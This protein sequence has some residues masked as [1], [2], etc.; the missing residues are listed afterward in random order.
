MGSSL[1]T[2]PVFPSTVIRFPYPN[3]PQRDLKENP[4]PAPPSSYELAAHSPKEAIRRTA[5]Y[6]VTMPSRRRDGCLPGFEN[7]PNLSRALQEYPHLW[8][9]A[10]LALTMGSNG[11]EEGDLLSH[12]ADLQQIPSDSLDEI[13]G[14]LNDI[15][16]NIGNQT[17][18]LLPT[19]RANRLFLL[20]ETE[21]SLP[22]YR[23]VLALTVMA[24]LGQ[25]MKEVGGSY[26]LG[27]TVYRDL[28]LGNQLR[29]KGQH[30]AA[31]EQYYQPACE[32]NPY[33]LCAL[34]AAQSALASQG[35]PDQ[36][37]LQSLWEKYRQAHAEIR[38]IADTLS[39]VPSRRRVVLDYLKL[40]LWPEAVRHRSVAE[41]L[42]LGARIVSAI[43]NAVSKIVKLI[44]G[45]PEALLGII[46]ILGAANQQ[47]RMAHEIWG[48]G[49]SLYTDNFT[50][51]PKLF[52]NSLQTELI[53]QG[54]DELV[55]SEFERNLG[56]FD[57]PKLCQ[58]FVR[59]PSVFED[60]RALFRSGSPLNLCGPSKSGKTEAL[61]DAIWTLQ[62]EREAGKALWVFLNKNTKLEALA[63]LAAHMVGELTGDNGFFPRVFR[64]NWAG[65]KIL[66]IRK[67]LA[68]TPIPHPGRRPILVL[69]NWDQWKEI[70]QE[71]RAKVFF[72]ILRRHCTLVFISTGEA[73]VDAPPES[74]LRIGEVSYREAM[75]ILRRGFG[76]DDQNVRR[77]MDRKAQSL[78]EGA[79]LVSD[80][81]KVALAHGDDPEAF[82]LPEI[83]CPS[84][85]AI[86]RTAPTSPPSPKT[87]SAAW[88]AEDHWLS[89]IERVG[90]Y[91][92]ILLLGMTVQNE[93][94]RLEDAMALE[95]ILIQDHGRV[96]NRSGELRNAFWQLM[97]SGFFFSRADN[98]FE[99]PD[100]LR[101]LI[102]KH[103][104]SERKADMAFQ[105]M[106]DWRMHRFRVLKS[107]GLPTRI[108]PPP[109]KRRTT[110]SGIPTIKKV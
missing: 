20:L 100:H 23:N 57:L 24:G 64:A 73:P 14:L 98:L 17:C 30:A 37:P 28:C 58:N 109:L 31:L 96:G 103:C 62:A 33:S 70:G 59:R 44:F 69:D 7:Y 91:G 47:Y 106:N 10:E 104:F 4:K 101:P 61:S 67:A 110:L 66:L 105:L 43:F 86:S 55:L 85:P 29:L 35:E 32:I 108:L 22:N 6:L 53:R 40:R 99:V 45:S 1:K 63:D 79:I 68:A 49:H 74:I 95:E 60:I 41:N 42:S 77:R 97:G 48:V 9:Y 25:H 87:S 88:S 90:P 92:K 19:E 52:P 2:P 21:A 15:E 38:Q 8:G 12:L 46:K 36:E 89:L 107:A 13:R 54:R 81:A 78:G 84:I 34:E 82:P 3:S 83:T 102:L 94:V 65:R 76:I 16:K 18:P 71:K 56:N 11:R 51:I 26:Y 5:K 72:A 75:E 93:A 39:K 80:I 27:Y 50:D